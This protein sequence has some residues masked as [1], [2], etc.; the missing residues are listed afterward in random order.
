[1]LLDLAAKETSVATEE[2]LA[3]V[4]E[5]GKEIADD[6]SEEKGFNFQN[7]IVEELSKAEKEEL[8]EYAISYDYQL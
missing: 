5:K 2:V 1:M 3:A 6:T 8:K 4:P 7:L